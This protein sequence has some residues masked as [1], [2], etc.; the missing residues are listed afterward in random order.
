MLNKVKCG[1]SV[2][3]GSTT[4]DDFRP[5]CDT[6]DSSDLITKLAERCPGIHAD[7]GSRHA[8]RWHPKLSERQG[9]FF[10]HKHITSMD[11][12]R[13]RQ[14]PEWDVSEELVE[15][16]L[17][18]ALAHEDLPVI[19]LN[20]KGEANITNQETAFAWRMKPERCS[21]VG[22]AEVMYRLLEAKLP[23][24]TKVWLE[25]EFR[26]SLDWL[27]HLPHSPLTESFLQVDKRT[28]GERIVDI[29][30]CL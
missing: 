7:L 14:W 17:A 4:D 12:D 19:S 25:R 22:W 26:V 21:H 23:G 1:A 13:I 6:I 5:A 18:Y 27:A 28:M 10:K 9:L 20:D 8:D 2:V 24:I 15:V 16:P 3:I 30:P 29:K 11:R